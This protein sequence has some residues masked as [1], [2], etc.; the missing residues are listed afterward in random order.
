MGQALQAGNEAFA[1]DAAPR[2]TPRRRPVSLLILELEDDDI[3]IVFPHVA[4]ML[5]ECQRERPA[6]QTRVV[7]FEEPP[8]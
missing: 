6:S 1:E 7:C 3:P 2:S 4:A 8:R 5:R